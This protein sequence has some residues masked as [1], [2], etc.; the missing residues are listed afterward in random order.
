MACVWLTLTSTTPSPFPQL[1]A[2]S[3]AVFLRILFSHSSAFMFFCLSSTYPICVPCSNLGEVLCPHHCFLTQNSAQF[4]TYACERLMDW[5]FPI[6]LKILSLFHI[7]PHK[8]QLVSLKSPHAELNSSSFLSSVQ[9]P[10]LLILSCPLSVTFKQGWSLS[11][12]Y[13]KFQL[14]LSFLQSQ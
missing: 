1:S 2:T 11:Q 5:L 6:K 13:L 12:D 14:C 3:N 10:L 8:C 4:L 7:F 9:T